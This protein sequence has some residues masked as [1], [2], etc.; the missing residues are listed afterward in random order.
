MI[1]ICL[2]N[3][4]WDLEQGCHLDFLKPFA[5]LFR[6]LLALCRYKKN[7]TE[8]VADLDKLNMVKL[9]YVRV[10]LG[11]EPIFTTAPSALKYDAYYKSGQVG[12]KNNHFD[13]FGLPPSFWPLPWYCSCT[14]RSVDTATND[15][16][17]RLTL[18]SGGPAGGH[19]AVSARPTWHRHQKFVPW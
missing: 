5:W 13:Q 16:P 18:R 6:N 4:H 7:D 3:H 12:L 1:R 8:C 2:R 14:R 9:C 19:G 10:V 11:S 15:G 17:A